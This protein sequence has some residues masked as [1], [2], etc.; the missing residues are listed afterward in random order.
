LLD[1]RSLTNTSF[2]TNESDTALPIDHF[3]EGVVQLLEIICAL[4]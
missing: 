2:A 3:G 4:E 1:Q